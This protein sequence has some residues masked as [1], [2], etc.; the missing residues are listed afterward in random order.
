MLGEPVFQS[1]YEP[2]DA[3]ASS[4][5]K[6]VIIYEDDTTVDEA[7]L[8]PLGI[9]QHKVTYVLGDQDAPLIPG[10]GKDQRIG[11]TFQAEIR[12][13]GRR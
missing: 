13:P 2:P 7:F 6:R 8:S 5:L 12:P 4:S 1:T 9:D 11:Q 3:G 10:E